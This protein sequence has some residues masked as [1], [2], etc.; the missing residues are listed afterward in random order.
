MMVHGAILEK[1][2]RVGTKENAEKLVSVVMTLLKKALDASM[3][4]KRFNG[5]NLPVYW[6]NPEIADKATCREKGRLGP[7]SAKR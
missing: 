6:W 2:R 7:Y 1:S 4:R 3:P 5:R